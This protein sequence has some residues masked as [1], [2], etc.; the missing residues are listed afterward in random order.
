[1]KLKPQRQLRTIDD[2]RKIP[3]WVRATVLASALICAGLLYAT[4]AKPSR[5]PPPPTGKTSERQPGSAC[6]ISAAIDP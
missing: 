6:R 4:L 1:M 5:K 3:A 2:P